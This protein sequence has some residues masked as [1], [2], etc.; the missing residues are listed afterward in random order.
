[1]ASFT[2]KWPSRC[3][4]CGV[5]FPAGSKVRWHHVYGHSCI[6]GIACNERAERSKALDSRPSLCENGGSET[7]ENKG[8]S[9]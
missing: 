5:F 7:G 9:R 3:Y 1:M 4:L 2:L 6:D 8:G